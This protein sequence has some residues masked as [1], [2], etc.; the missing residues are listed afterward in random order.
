MKYYEVAQKAFKESDNM[1][2]IHWRSSHYYILKI[3]F[4]KKYYFIYDIALGI[5]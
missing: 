5:F 1:Y 3:I 2:H 4:P